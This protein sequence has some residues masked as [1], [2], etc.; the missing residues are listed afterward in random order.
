MVCHCFVFCI[1]VMQKAIIIIVIHLALNLLLVISNQHM[2]LPC[3]CL[4]YKFHVYCKIINKL[5][6]P[7]GYN[8]TSPANFTTTKKCVCI[9]ENRKVNLPGQFLLL[10]ALQ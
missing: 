10:L 7:K 1:I 2:S 4:S 6:F 3:T 5:D 8:I 9:H